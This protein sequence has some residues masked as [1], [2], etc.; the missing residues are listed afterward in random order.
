[1]LWGLHVVLVGMSTDFYHQYAKYRH[2]T[3]LL[4]ITLYISLVMLF[5]TLVKVLNGGQVLGYL[6]ENISSIK[7]NLIFDIYELF[8]Y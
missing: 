3:N 7:S 6:E 1:M 8:E 2:Y 4:S 5:G